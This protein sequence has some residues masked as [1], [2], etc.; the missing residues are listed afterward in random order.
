MLISFIIIKYN[1]EERYWGWVA[2]TWG[3]ALQ[4]KGFNPPLHYYFIC[5]LLRVFYANKL[6][7]KKKKVKE[8]CVP[9]HH[10]IPIEV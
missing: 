1:Q 5:V 7:F 4:S 3:S 9:G 6:P 10:A 2:A 8:I